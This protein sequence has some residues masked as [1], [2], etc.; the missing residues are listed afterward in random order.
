MSVAG[1]S[2]SRRGLM[3]VLSSPS[4]AGKSTIARHLMAE[5]KDIV[6]SVSVTTRARR[7]SEIDGVH[8]HFIDQPTF[9]KLRDKGEL[10]EWAEVHGNCYGTP[11]APVEAWLTSGKDVLFDIDWQGADQVAKAMPE[12]LV[13]IFVLPPTMAELASRLVRR[14]ED[15]PDVIAKRLANARAEIQH[16]RDYDYVLINKDLQTSLEKA[17]AI[18]YA[19]RMRR[20]R[21]TWLE[22]FVG[23]LLQQA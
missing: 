14:A 12:D 5:D 17:Q 13:R 22:G 9:N 19:E 20:A 2:P 21:T 10:L 8:Y 16:W 3:L 1:N 11:R 18:L 7:P 23:D 15:A 4:G 6:L